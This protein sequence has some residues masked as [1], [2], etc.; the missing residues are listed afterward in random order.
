MLQCC[1]IVISAAIFNRPRVKHQQMQPIYGQVSL[2][3]PGMAPSPGCGPPPGTP[4]TSWNAVDGT[5]TGSSS[6]FSGSNRKSSS[7]TINMVSSSQHEFVMKGTATSWQITNDKNPTSTGSTTNIIKKH[8]GGGLNRVTKWM[9]NNIH[10]CKH[11][12]ICCRLAYPQY[13]IF[14]VFRSFQQP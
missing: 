8:D 4:T 12:C 11:N 10:E 3:C 5:I 6:S 7:K 13:H 9:V 2:S 14:V 1:S